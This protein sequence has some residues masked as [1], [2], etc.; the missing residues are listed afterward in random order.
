MKNPFSSLIKPFFSFFQDFFSP[1]KFFHPKFRLL[2]RGVIPILLAYSLGVIDFFSFSLEK[3][4]QEEASVISFPP[5]GL[6]KKVELPDTGPW[7][8]T[9]EIGEGDTL[10]AILTKIGIPSSQSFEAI[11]ALKP[12]FNPRELKAGQEISVRYTLPVSGKNPKIYDLLEISLRPDVGYAFHVTRQTNGS[13]QATREK[14]ELAYQDVIVQGSISM[15]LYRDALREGADPQVLHEVIR[16]FSYDVNFQLDFH[17][18]DAF[19][20]FY[21][22]AIDEETGMSRPEGL[23]FA[24]LTLG[25]KVHK[26]YRFASQKGE[27]GFYTETGASVRKDLLKTPVDGA[28]L[29]SRFGKRRHPILGYTKFHKGVDFAAPTGTPIMAAGN[30][31]IEK[32]FFNKAYGNYILIRHNS[33]YKTAYAHLSRYARGVRPGRHVKQGDIIGYIGSTGRS[34]GPHLHFELIQ[35]GKQI[36][37]QLVKLMPG[38]A[39]NGQELQ[40]FRAYTVKVQKEF[41]ETLE[42]GDGD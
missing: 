16:A 8:E 39:L 35:G 14:K 41:N 20:L 4:P 3:S 34:T 18:G 26:I 40:A 6:E 32:A 42:K 11:A 24:T 7:D 5:E 19:C 2:W 22:E 23:F 33:G 17:P 37:P 27:S 29:S 36:N 13:F 30:G 31:V 9:L 1:Q 25:G 28:R 10:M 21:R 12:L 38:S 15:S